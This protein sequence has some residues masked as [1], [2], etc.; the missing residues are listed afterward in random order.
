[1]AKERNGFVVYHD[2]K[3]VLDNLSDKQG[4]TLF[5][6]FVQY[7]I[8]GTILEMDEVTKIVFL[9]YKSR[10][11]NEFEKYKTKCK[12][13]QANV[14]KRYKSKQMQANVNKSNQIEIE[15]EIEKEK[16]IEIEI[17]KEKEIDDYI[18]ESSSALPLF[19]SLFEINPDVSSMS[20]AKDLDFSKVIKAFA[21]SKWLKDEM[22]SLKWVVNNYHK[23][24]NGEYKDRPRKEQS[25]KERYEE[26]LAK[27]LAWAEQKDRED[28][29]RR[30][31]NGNQTS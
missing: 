28:E 15:K 10:L 31:A 2:I 12:Q 18:C 13:M 3:Q 30:R 11:D 26:A 5:K 22:K 7:S 21:E 16:E 25:E 4:A 9:S 6:A 1:M 14:N 20:I 24:I 23:I 29:E 19:I 17:E 27:K 8:D